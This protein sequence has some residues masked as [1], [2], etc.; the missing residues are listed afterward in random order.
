MTKKVTTFLGLIVYFYRKKMKRILIVCLA[1]ILLLVSCIDL[2]DLGNRC[3]KKIRTDKVFTTDVRETEATLNMSWIDNANTSWSVT[4]YDLD[5]NIVAQNQD[6]T[7]TFISIEK[8][9]TNAQYNITIKGKKKCPKPA[10][11]G[12]KIGPQGDVQF[13]PGKAPC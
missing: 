13:C 2:G 12:L 11:I 7:N 10:D 4:V 9:P 5:G 3:R 8:I 1:S 6:I